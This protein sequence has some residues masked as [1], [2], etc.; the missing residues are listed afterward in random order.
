MKLILVTLVAAFFSCAEP[1]QEGT[2]VKTLTPTEYKEKAS[3]EGVL[4]DVRT[5]EE[6]AAGHLTEATNSNFL[7]GTFAESIKG[8]D[9]EKTYYLYCASGNRSG[10]AAKLMQEAGFKNVYNIGGYQ[11]LKSAG[12]P[13][14]E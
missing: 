6:Y 9:Q 2:A 14:K 5:P 4:V 7:D 11:S 10:K 12:L 13:T 1:Q 3:K 8:W